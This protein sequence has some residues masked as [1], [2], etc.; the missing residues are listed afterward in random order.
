M[1]CTDIRINSGC[2]H[3][4]HNRFV[5]ITDRERVHCAVPEYLSILQVSLRL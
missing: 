5:F 2:F 3:T 1:F 4:Q